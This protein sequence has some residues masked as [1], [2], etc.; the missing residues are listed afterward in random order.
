MKAINKISS[1]T[2][3]VLCVIIIAAP[4]GFV[5]FFHYV[6]STESEQPENYNPTESFNR[7]YSINISEDADVLYCKSNAFGWFGDGITYCVYNIGNDDIGVSWN[8][9]KKVA[10]EEEVN[11]LTSIL[12]EDFKDEDESFVIEYTFDWTKEYKWYC[13]YKLNNTNE[14]VDPPNEVPIYYNDGFFTF[15]VPDEHK[16]YCIEKKV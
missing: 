2:L 7:N 4:V 3:T 5:A 10:F 16:L 12:I 13:I 9:E 15:F 8:E 14:Y 6:F 11:N 1:I